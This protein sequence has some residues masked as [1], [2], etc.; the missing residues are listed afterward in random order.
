MCSTGL[1]IDRGIGSNNYQ[2]IRPV[3]EVMK[4]IDKAKKM[5]AHGFAFSGGEPTLRKDLPMLVKY[6]K[7]Q[8]LSHI[9]V[10]S[11][12]KMYVYKDYCRKLVD[13]GVN[14]F[15]IS[16]HSHKEDV[17]DKIV[18]V[19]GTF[20]Q[21]KEGIKNLNDLGQAVK[22]NIVLTKFNYAHLEDFVKFLLDYD[23]SEIRF[24]MVM[25]EG[26]AAKN[27]KQIVPK[28]SNVAP[29]IMKSIAIAKDTIDCYVYNMVPCLLPGYESYINDMKQ[30][31]TILVGPDFEASLDEERKGKK[32]KRGACKQCR[33]DK[34]CSGVWKKYAEV[35]G[36]GELKAVK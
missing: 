22:I 32:V 7:A 5:K 11:N 3:H 2:V 9:E 23:I 30:L 10:Q 19:P 28:M 33:F 14:N 4:D 16:L 17:H 36:V 35:Y 29:H 26:H 31:D 21:A 6:A 1:Q 24:T 15:V 25:V 20:R 34:E 12:G 13:S 18:G 27:P 8:G